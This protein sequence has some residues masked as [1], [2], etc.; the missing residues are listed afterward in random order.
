[1]RVAN[2]AYVF[3]HARYSMIILL[4]LCYI[5]NKYLKYL[6]ICAQPVLKCGLVRSHTTLWHHYH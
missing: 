1:V 2:S 6:A 4:V 3:R 5:L